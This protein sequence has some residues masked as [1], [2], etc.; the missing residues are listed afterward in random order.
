MLNLRLFFIIIIRD[1]L[2]NRKF[3]LAIYFGM[4]PKKE[5][6]K[7]KK[8][9]KRK[10]KERRKKKLLSYLRLVRNEMV[11]IVHS[12]GEHIPLV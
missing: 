2:F 4:L 8:K 5:K 1:F 12:L 9:K 10:K 3:Y 6:K 7:K 11:I